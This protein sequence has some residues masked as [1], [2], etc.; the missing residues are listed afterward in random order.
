MGVDVFSIMETPKTTSSPGW[1][2]HLLVADARQTMKIQFDAEADAL[3][4]R[5]LDNNRFAHDDGV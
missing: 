4:L 2:V 1:T 5:I 3:Y